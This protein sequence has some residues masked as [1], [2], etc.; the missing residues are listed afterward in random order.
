[1]TRYIRTSDNMFMYKFGNQS[2][3]TQTVKT[4]RDASKTCQLTVYLSVFSNLKLQ[5]LL[6]LMCHQFG[7]KLQREHFF[8]V[9]FLCIRLW[10]I[11]DNYGTKRVCFR[12]EISPLYYSITDIYYTKTAVRQNTPHV[13]S[14]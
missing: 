2:P 4:V 10:L 1:M 13:R 6:C 9:M 8:S 7:W 14:Y 11:S 5:P 12:G 3:P